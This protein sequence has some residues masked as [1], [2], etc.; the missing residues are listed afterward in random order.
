M[1][2]KAISFL[3]NEMLKNTMKVYSLSQALSERDPTSVY[4]SINESL[5]KV[6]KN[7]T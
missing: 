7:E 5:E 2:D 3:V 4:D 1:V 6:I